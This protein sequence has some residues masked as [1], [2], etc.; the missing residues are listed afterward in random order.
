MGT[1]DCSDQNFLNKMPIKLTRQEYLPQHGGDLQHAIKTHG[2]S[3]DQWLDMSTG[4]SPWSWPVPALSQ[5]VWHKL[6]PSSTGV[7]EAAAQFYQQPLRQLAITPGSQLTIRLL[8]QLFERA[9]VAVPKLGY[10]EHLHSWRMAG[11]KVVFYQ[12]IAAL[13]ELVTSSRV[14]HAVVI[15]PN[16]PTGETASQPD[17]YTISQAISGHLLIDHAFADLSTHTN[18]YPTNT[19]VLKSLGKFFGLAGLRVGF[20][21]AD[22]S[23]ID[24]INAIFEPWSIAGPSMAVAEAALLDIA[25]H[26]KQ[27]ARIQHNAQAFEETL[28]KLVERHGLTSSTHS[29]LFHTLFSEQS[30]IDQLHYQLASVGIWSR[31]YN[32]EDKSYWLRLSL[33]HCLSE[34]SNRIAKLTP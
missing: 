27:R 30:K 25:W 3:K 21:V 11:H 7:L 16:N 5:D 9:V 24:S 34:F 6:P 14:D 31:R 17:L 33:P 12:D 15:T 13:I 10:Q 4:I 19:I 23:V 26:D 8:P 22:S 1:A 32:R 2:L 20:V 29:G 28:R 18:I